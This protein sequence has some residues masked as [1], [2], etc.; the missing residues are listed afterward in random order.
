MKRH[1]PEV[2]AREERLRKA[3]TDRNI[4]RKDATY[5][6][7]KAF[8]KA[9]KILGYRY[10]A[11]PEQLRLREHKYHAAL[12]Q[13][14][15]DVREFSQKDK[16][17]LNFSHCRR[18]T[19]D[20][21]VFLYANL[22]IIRDTTGH[23][24][25]RVAE[26]TL[27]GGVKN[28]VRASGLIEMLKKQEV[29]PDFGSVKQPPVIHGRE[30]L[31]DEILDYIQN[32]IYQGDLDPDIENRLGDALSETFL[33]VND[34]AYPKES[35]PGLEKGPWW[36]IC[37]VFDGQLWLAIYDCGVGIPQT[38]TEDHWLQ[39]HI[40]AYSPDQLQLF[41]NDDADKIE[42]AMME[43]QNRREVEK[44][45]QG[46]ASMHALVEQNPNGELW[47]YSNHG[48]YNWY[49][50]ENKKASHKKAKYPN[51]INGTLIQWNVAIHYEK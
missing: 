44:H 27:S 7:K 26:N 21:L 17:R 3:R 14:I 40:K 9:P 36:A 41:I 32:S 4:K 37:S 19:A 48:R 12:I 23:K 16:V 47:V 45:G 42:L 33:N 1:P 38:I 46:S 11:V 51:S 2:V 6:P 29:K 18:A 43:G 25:I 15:K 8:A 34:H 31:H 35:F 5:D 30:S 22:Q 10:I 20:A 49:R 39:K 50:D 13:L 28:W 24:L